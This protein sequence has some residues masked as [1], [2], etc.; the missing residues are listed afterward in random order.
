MTSRGPLHPIQFHGP[1]THLE[2]KPTHDSFHKPTVPTR[3]KQET[4]LGP[5]SADNYINHCM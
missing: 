1:S 2:E 5:S 4:Y 3:W